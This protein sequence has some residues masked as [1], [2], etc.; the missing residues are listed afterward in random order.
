MTLMETNIK[1][2][3]FISFMLMF[4]FMLLLI[5]LISTG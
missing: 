3:R 4:A 2:L 1:I 5:I